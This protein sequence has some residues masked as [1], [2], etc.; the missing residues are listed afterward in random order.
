MRNFTYWRTE[1]ILGCKD[2]LW[3]ANTVADQYEGADIWWHEILSK[4]IIQNCDINS[5]E[6]ILKIEA[7]MQWPQKIFRG[8]E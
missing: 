2:S 4:I 6:T 7:E 1:K 3:C 5:E 8:K